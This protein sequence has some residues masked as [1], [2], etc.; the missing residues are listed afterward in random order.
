MIVGGVVVGE[1]RHRGSTFFLRHRS[2]DRTFSPPPPPPP[3]AVRA[4]SEGAPLRRKSGEERRRLFPR[5]RWSFPYTTTC[6]VYTW[7]EGGGELCDGAHDVIR[8]YR[9]DIEAGGP[10]FASRLSRRIALARD[11]GGG[12]AEEEEEQEEEKASVLET[13]YA[14]VRAHHVRRALSGRARRPRR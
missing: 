5:E 3:S 4:E 9:R 6:D 11:R 8:Y 10:L 1:G 14:A 7:V 2:N 12:V 13:I